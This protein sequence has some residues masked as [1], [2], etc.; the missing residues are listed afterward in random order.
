MEDLTEVAAA[1][2]SFWPI[3]CQVPNYENK[4]PGSRQNEKGAALS[5]AL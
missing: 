3:D 5:I 2:L 4:T 1:A